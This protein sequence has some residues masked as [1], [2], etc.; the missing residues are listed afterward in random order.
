MRLASLALQAVRLVL[1]VRVVMLCPDAMANVVGLVLLDSLLVHTIEGLEAQLDVREE[2]V[3]SRLGE[4]LS[5]YHSQHLQILGMRRHRVCRDNPATLPQLV[6]HGEFV[7]MLVVF[8]IKAECNEREAFAVLLG[9]DDETQLVQRISKVIGGPSEVGHDGAVAMLAE[10]DQLIVLANDL[11]SALG[12]V[13]REGGLVRAEVI[14][15]KD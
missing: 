3:T 5:D 13:E 11:G 10:T 9:H 15:V 8:G 12:E 2:G 6:G 14:D 4:V 7:V 1:V